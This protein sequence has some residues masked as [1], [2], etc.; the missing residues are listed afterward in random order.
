MIDLIFGQF[1]LK[2]RAEAMQR[3]KEGRG[4]QDDVDLFKAN[5]VRLTVRGLDAR[6]LRDARL[7]AEWASI[8]Y[9]NRLAP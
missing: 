8:T 9:G 6:T 2:S 3:L 7:T 5:L 1:S 4:T